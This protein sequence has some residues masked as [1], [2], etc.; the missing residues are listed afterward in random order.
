[1]NVQQDAGRTIK[2]A[3][4]EIIPKFPQYE[5]QIKMYYTNHRKMIKGVFFDSIEIL[6][7]LKK[8]NYFCYVLSNWSAE[9]FVGMTE[10]YP[11]LKQFD[12]LLISG[13]DNLI[14]PDPAIYKLA[15]QRFDLDPEKTVFIDD[16]LE[17]IETARKLNFNT[18][19]LT[20][21]ETIKVNIN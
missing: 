19:H 3:E 16:K 15:I 7:K 20:N 18:I 6:D 9:T 11:F 21:P 1:W 5:Q 8:N 14:K 2:E 4:E 17:N 13:Q 10:D 12:G